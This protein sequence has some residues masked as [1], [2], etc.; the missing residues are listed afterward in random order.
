M[1]NLIGHSLGRYHL[2][3]TLGEGGMAVVY[4]AYDN[5]LEREV[6]VKVI[7]RNAFS[8]DAL[9]RVLKRFDR[10]AK[11][12]GKLTH[13]NIVPII[14]YGE[15]ESYPYLVMPYLTGGTLKQYLKEHR[16]MDWWEAA[17]ILVP[18]AEALTYARA[19]AHPPGC[20]T[21][22]HPSLGKGSTDADG[23]RCGKGGG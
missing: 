16:R 4:K 1:N 9:E 21:F 6:A 19:G 11:S 18:V 12:L 17:R 7:R 23:F 10:E 22:K 3:E 15:H 5:H 13:P 8:P 2:L 14:D 20:K